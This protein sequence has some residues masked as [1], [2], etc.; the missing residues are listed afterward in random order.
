MKKVAYFGPWVGEFGWEAMTWQAYCRKLSHDFKK[1]YVCSYP[2]SDALYTDFAEF[3]A[4]D[5]KRVYLDWR[6]VSKIDYRIPAGVTHH[7][8]PIKECRVDG[9][10]IQFGTPVDEY[11]FLV[12]ARGISK[13]AFRNYPLCMWEQ[14]ADQL[15][16]AIATVGT[17]LDGLVPGTT[18]LRGIPLS[19]LMNYMAG[20]ELV[21]GQNTGVLHLACLC[22]ARRVVW[23]DHTGFHGMTAEER[24]KEVWNPFR[25]PTI[26]IYADGW[27]PQPE[28]IIEAIGRM[29]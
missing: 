10:F 28:S 21:V 18:D 3:I 4:H 23:G 20:C 1:C 16:G 29:L 25:T 27:Q 9:E 22:G 24:F 5:H 26:Y 13:S 2:S 15:D 6:D 12:H 14:V 19:E 17:G 7:I 8:M 11:K